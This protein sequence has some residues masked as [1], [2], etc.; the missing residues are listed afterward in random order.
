VRRIVLLPIGGVAEMETIPD[1]PAQELVIALAGPA[2]N[3]VL[4]GIL[5]LVAQA[6]GLPTALDPRQL[7]AIGQ[8]DGLLDGGLIFSYIFMANLFIG[9]FN[10]APAFPLDG[11]RVLRALLA[12][13]MPYVRATSIA[14]GIG[15]T[16]AFLLGLWG[17]LTFNIFIII[18][19]VFVYMG[20]SQEGQMVQVRGVLSNIR[21]RQAYTRRVL[22][23]SPSDPISRAV[24]AM[25]HTFQS[26]FPVLDGGHLVGML[27]AGDVMT[28]LRQQQENAQVS[29]VMR[30]DF[31][32]AGPEETIFDVQQRMAAAG[33]NAVPIVEAGQLVG[34]LT[35][36]DVSELYTLL[37]I[38]PMLLG[39]RQ[40]L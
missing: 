28:A 3:F 16:L 32:M 27:T 36:R 1:K 13:R 37:S 20:A 5:W 22:A 15:Q 40:P 26:D 31:P 21:V 34:V 24:E 23:L 7:L 2:V 39:R 17:V 10:L 25:L 18:L 35:T 29:E 9:V 6:I 30:S 33:V 8:Q 14:V 12:L 38:N 4:A 19:A 11:G